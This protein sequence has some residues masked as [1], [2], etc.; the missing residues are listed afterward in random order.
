MGFAL[1]L[2]LFFFFGGGGGIFGSE[3]E[4]QLRFRARQ[5]RRMLP[6]HRSILVDVDTFGLLLGEGNVGEDESI[7]RRARGGFRV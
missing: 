5:G 3:P 4:H 1:F 7:G 2:F 6:G